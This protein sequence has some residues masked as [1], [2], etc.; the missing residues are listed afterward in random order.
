MAR[1]LPNKLN[2]SIRLSLHGEINSKLGN[3]KKLIV[4]WVVIVDLPSFSQLKHCSSSYHVEH[5]LIIPCE[6]DKSFVN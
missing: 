4:A 6:I 5:I 1:V 2:A 3:I